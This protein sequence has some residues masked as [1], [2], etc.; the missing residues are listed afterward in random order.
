MYG[1]IFNCKENLPI[2]DRALYAEIADVHDKESL[3]YQ[4]A[5]TLQFP[6][7]FNYTWKSLSECMNELEWLNG[8]KV[9]IIHDNLSSLPDSD[10]KTYINILVD[11]IYS[12]IYSMERKDFC[13]VFSSEDKERVMAAIDF[14]F[15]SKEDVSEIKDALRVDITDASDKEAL[16]IQMENKFHFPYFG[17]NWDALYECITDLEW[18]EEKNVIL[19]HDHL[20]RMPDEV[21]DAYIDVLIDAVYS[22]KYWPLRK[23]F[24]QIGFYIVFSPLDNDRIKK[25]IRRHFS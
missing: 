11:S 8:R 17:H 9:I 6:P 20:A 15:C 5:E 22:W 19:C 10:F 18:I 3:F 1:L 7:C 23:G 12:W 14:K 21:L 13:V 16:F 2:A 4:I 24:E 25:A